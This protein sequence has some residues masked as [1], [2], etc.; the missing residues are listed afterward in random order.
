VEADG[1]IAAWAFRLLQGGGPPAGDDRQEPDGRFVE[2]ARRN[3]ILV[4][5]EEALRAQ[6]GSVATVL[7]DAAAEERRRIQQTVGFVGELGDLCL[8]HGIAFVFTKAFQHYPDM[9]H[10]VDLFVGDRSDQIDRLIRRAYPC[11]PGADSLSNR[12]AG[13]TSWE[14]EGQPTPVEVH[15]GRLGHVGEHEIYAAMLVRRRARL[16]IGE[17]TTFVPSAEDQVILQALQRVYGHGTV[18]VSDVF[19]T[20]RLLSGDLDRDYVVKTTRRIG[21]L[22]GLCCYLRYVEA[23]CRTVGESLPHP[24]TWKPL[25]A[26]GWGDIRLRGWHYRFPA[27][28]VF[29]RLYAGKLAH[30]LASGDWASAGRLL[31]LP[32]LAAVAAGRA[33]IRRAARGR[34]RQ[35]P[36]R[37]VESDAQASV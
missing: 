26:R 5:C 36:G 12:V 28:W 30:D 32:P 10:D 2:F 20:I 29:G 9:G 11:A 13:K 16:D 1:R 14:V 34:D 24:E 18:R 15:H 27:M 33:V 4:R 35:S 7:G 31:L 6:G 37:K 17:I 25:A 8:R 3:V 23:I 19:H 21:I 22:A